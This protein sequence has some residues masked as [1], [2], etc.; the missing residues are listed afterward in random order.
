MVGDSLKHDTRDRAGRIISLILVGLTI[1]VAAAWS[2]VTQ[3]QLAASIMRESTD[4]LVHAGATFQAIRTRT[5]LIAAVCALAGR[6][7]PLYREGCS[8]GHE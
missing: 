4:H 6:R 2:L 5:V 8:G 1:A 7:R 3:R